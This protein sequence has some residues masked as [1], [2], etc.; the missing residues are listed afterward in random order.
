MFVCS[1]NDTGIHYARQESREDRD[2]HKVGRKT[3]PTEGSG[4]E[5]GKT[6]T[7]EQHSSEMFARLANLTIVTDDLPSTPSA[8]HKTRVEQKIF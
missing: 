5:K 6:S 1:P 8:E 4:E 7:T 3:S 2:D